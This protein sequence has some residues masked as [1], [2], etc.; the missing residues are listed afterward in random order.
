MSR[1]RDDRGSVI[2]LILGFWLLAL[3]LVAG[4]VALGDALTKQR[5]LQAICDGTAIAAAN[6]VDPARTHAGALGADALPLTAA[7]LAVRTYL[8]RDGEDTGVVA[9]ATV[10]PDG[11]TVRV[12]CRRHVRLAFGAVFGQGGGIDQQADADAR[13]PLDPG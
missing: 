4:A 2:P 11:I 1:C 3:I 5:D 6:S 7:R 8:A 10:D 9:D 13:S 12:S